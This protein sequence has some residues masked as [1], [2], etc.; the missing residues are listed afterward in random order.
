MN[1]LKNRVY[2]L[3]AIAP[4]PLHIANRRKDYQ[5]QGISPEK[6]YINQRLN[7][8]MFY[9]EQLSVAPREKS[10]E[11]K[12]RTIRDIIMRPLTTLESNAEQQS[13]Q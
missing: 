3:K 5:H 1:E 2:A 10:M 4:V 13:N 7:V 8:G 9:M 6:N 12:S 11:E